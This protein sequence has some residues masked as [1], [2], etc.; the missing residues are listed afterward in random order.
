MMDP[1]LGM[2]GTAARVKKKVPYCRSALHKSNKGR[3][4]MLVFMVLSNCS[5]VMSVMLVWSYYKSAPFSYAGG[6]TYHN[7]SVVD[8]DIDPTPSL[9]TL[10]NDSVTSLLIPDVLGDEETFSTSSVDELLGFFG[11]N[12]FLG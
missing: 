4:T 10:L 9:Y 7:G 12:L 2:C 5:V 3:L 8:Q 6:R 1:P 11:V